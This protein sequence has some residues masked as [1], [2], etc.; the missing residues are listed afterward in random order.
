MELFTVKPP[1]G[2]IQRRIWRMFLVRPNAAITTSDLCLGAY[3]RAGGVITHNHRRAVRGA[4]LA[5][6]VPVGRSKT[7]KGRP[8]LW[9]AKG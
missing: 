2:P 3:P 7:G 1:Q 6:A 8:L 4:A 9:K 5:V